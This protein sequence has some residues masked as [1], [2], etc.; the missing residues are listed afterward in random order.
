[1][2][3]SASKRDLNESGGPYFFPVSPDVKGYRVVAFDPGTASG[4]FCEVWHGNGSKDAE[5]MFYDLPL[6]NGRIDYET[7]VKDMPI[8]D[9]AYTTYVIEDVWVMPKQGVV[10]SAK[11]IEAYAGVKALMAQA[12]AC[13]WTNK[14]VGYRPQEWKKRWSLTNEK[15]SSCTLM[16]TAYPSLKESLAQYSPK[17][18][19]QL[20][21]LNHNRADAFLL[22]MTPLKFG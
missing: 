20:K 1:M 12:A 13:S 7:L 11:F 14:L 2:K 16:T 19:R 3:T 18:G 10:S 21:S 4:T 6:L 8:N 15:Q 17:T 9:Q 22:A 5:V